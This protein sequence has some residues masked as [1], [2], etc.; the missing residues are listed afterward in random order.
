LLKYAKE[1]W[2]REMDVVEFFP[3]LDWLPAARAPQEIEMLQR[4]IA[5]TDQAID[6]LVY[7]L[8]GLTQAEIKI[9]EAA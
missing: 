8:C 7:Q 2:C 6:A 4:E 5:S 1:I 3:T 9:I